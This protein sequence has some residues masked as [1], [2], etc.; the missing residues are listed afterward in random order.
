[1]AGFGAGDGARTQTQDDRGGRRRA[2]SLL[3]VSLYWAVPRAAMGRGTGKGAAACG[4]DRDE[5]Q[6]WHRLGAVITIGVASLILFW[7]GHLSGAGP[8]VVGVIGWLFGEFGYRAGVCGVSGV[9][10]RTDEGQSLQFIGMLCTVGAGVWDVYELVE[11]F[12][13]GHD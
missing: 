3:F 11:F 7:G 13:D 8:F 5:M 4:M 12:G 10:G 2:E 6:N 9:D 1:V